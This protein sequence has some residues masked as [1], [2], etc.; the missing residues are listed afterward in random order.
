MMVLYRFES[1]KWMKNKK[2]ILLMGL[3]L[4]LISILMYQV[5]VNE[6]QFQRDY[7]NNIELNY[8]TMFSVMNTLSI[9]REESANDNIL[10]KKIKTYDSILSDLNDEYYSLSQGDWQKSLKYRKSYLSSLLELREM[11]EENTLYGIGKDLSEEL[12]INNI[13]IKRNITPIP[14]TGSIQGIYFI[15]LILKSCLSA[16]GIVFVLICCFDFFSQE[17]EKNTM[18][19][20]LVQPFKKQQFFDA[21]SKVLMTIVLFLLLVSSLLYGLIGSILSRGI[22]RYDYPLAT[23]VKTVDEIHV[24][25]LDR[26]MFIQLWFIILIVCFMVLIVY[27]LSL[28]TKNSVLVFILSVSISVIPIYFFKFIS[29]KSSWVSYLPFYY[30]DPSSNI[31]KEFSNGTLIVFMIKGSVS[32]IGSSLILF[33]LIRQFQKSHSLVVH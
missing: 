24:L 3:L 22:G 7:L 12:R 11:G 15:E 13:L 20:L 28:I 10:D 19:L 1:L 9:Q 27:Y 23:Y 14:K 4:L 6:N 2:N 21:K 32:L 17:L 33:L 8:D 16:I 5:K 26:L 29:K 18:N 30:F 31:I 25:N